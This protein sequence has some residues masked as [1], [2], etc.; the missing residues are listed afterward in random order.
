[1]LK[2][3]L[4]KE[5]MIRKYGVE[6]YTQSTEFNI[7]T[8]P[9]GSSWKIFKFPSGKEVKIQGYEDKVLHDLLSKYDENDIIVKNSE[10]EKFIGK[11]WYYHDNK[12]HRYFPDI[13]IISENMIVEV[14]SHWTFSRHKDLNLLKEKACKDIGLN[15]QFVIL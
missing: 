7:R 14:K 11:I 15:F 1:M 10:I 5:G 6:N 9:F 2:S 13:F 3:S 12:K 8:H 4:A